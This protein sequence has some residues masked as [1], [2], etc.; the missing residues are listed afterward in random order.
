MAISFEL[1]AEPRTDTG[2]GASRRLRHAGKIPAIMYG[3]NKDP[4]AL[5]REIK[6]DLDVE[7]PRVAAQP[8]SCVGDDVAGMFP[9]LTDLPAP[10]RLPLRQRAGPEP[11]VVVQEHHVT[12]GGQVKPPVNGAAKI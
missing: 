5:T 11:V 7:A 9:I 3:G 10:Q 8:G 2:K 6:D 1:N 4:E 12:A